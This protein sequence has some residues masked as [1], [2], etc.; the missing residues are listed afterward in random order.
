MINDTQAKFFTQLNKNFLKLKEK[1]INF[2]D[3]LEC[4]KPKDIIQAEGKM[5]S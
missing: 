4:I 2:D 1:I 3:D 5:I